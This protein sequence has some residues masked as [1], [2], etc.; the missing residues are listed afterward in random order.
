MEPP[1]SESAIEA[2][3]VAIARELLTELGD[4][5]GAASRLSASDSLD[6]DLGLDS[7]ARVELLLRVQRAFGVDLPQR[8][9]ER[10]QSLRDIADAV[11]RAQAATG[12][13][14]APPEGPESEVQAAPS[15]PTPAA[16]GAGPPMPAGADRGAAVPGATVPGATVPGAG[17]LPHPEQAATLQAVLDW[18]CERHGERTQ[19]TLIDDDGAHAIDY[20][21]L[22]AGALRV[23]G[24]LLERGL[25]PGQSVALMLPT[26]LEYFFAYFGVL[27]AGGVPVPIYP[28]ARMAQIEEHVR[29]HAGI[30]GNARAVL[31]ITVPEARPI[32]RVLQAHVPSLEGVLVAG[33]LMR[34]DPATTPVARAADDVALVQYTSGSTGDPKGVVLT[35]ANLLANLRAVGPA[36][37]LR[38]DDVFVSWLP[39]YHDMGLIG[40]WFGTLYYGL[41]LVVMSPLAFLSRPVRWLR[42]ISEHRGTL[43][44]APNFAYELCTAKIDDA[45]LAGID[46]SSWRVAFNG[47]EAVL[48]ETLEHFAQRFSACGLRREA[49]FPVYGLAECCVAL[50]FPPLDRGPR[51]DRVQRE[52]F[53]VSRQALQ[54]AADEANPLRFVSC[55]RPVPGHAIRVI[56]EGGGALDERQEGRVLFRGP[57]TTAGYLDNPKANAALFRDGWLDSGDRGYL[58]DG[59]LFLTG[60]VKDIVI[61][62]GRNIYPHEVEQ[63]VGEVAG[64]R[65]GCVAVFGS[66]DPVSG[67]ERLVV[68]AETRIEQAPARDRLRAAIGDR[69]LAALGEPPDRVV[70]APPHTVLKTSSGKIRRAACRELFESGRIG[71]RR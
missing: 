64:V 34:A 24:G 65:K 13:G 18:H 32:A 33:D 8:T 10:A 39:L 44:A 20:Q 70:I 63:M 1:A 60:R 69:V 11:A 7:L 55:G 47:A 43:S 61:R 28:P 25:A 35:H 40:A 6:Q 58:A 22:R 54:A 49:L 36:L 37:A 31:M 71:A 12:P 3:L 56:D 42:T 16:R 57:S 53:V 59:E 68:L 5:P 27:L 19:I 48:P 17:P 41:P 62:G 23:A 30:L 52:A 29:R 2:R 15:G 9:L 4:R 67:T 50:A 38:A 46:L 21:A 14:A 45:E 26:S 66:P 51:I